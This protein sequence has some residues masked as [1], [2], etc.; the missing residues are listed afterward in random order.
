[1]TGISTIYNL[2]LGRPWIHDV[3]AVPSKLHQLLKF[4]MEDYEIFIHGEGSECNYLGFSV[5]VT[6]DFSQGTDFHKVEIMND[7]FED[8]TPQVS[9]TLVY[10]MLA[11]TMLRNGFEPGLCLVKN[12]DGIYEPLSI[13]LQNFHFAV[14]IPI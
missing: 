13:P 3:G 7:A 11:T 6:K 14:A 8:T 12:L 9:M 1:M 2:F 10:K 5:L 4:I